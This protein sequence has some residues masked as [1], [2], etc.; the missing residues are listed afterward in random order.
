LVND[1]E[2]PNT[3]DLVDTADPGSVSRGGSANTVIERASTPGRRLA[4]FLPAKLIIGMS[5][6]S[7]KDIKTLGSR[8]PNAYCRVMRTRVP[9]SRFSSRLKVP[10]RD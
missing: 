5:L 8:G 2:A 10:S 6:V 1:Q 7:A 3:G 9:S 4:A